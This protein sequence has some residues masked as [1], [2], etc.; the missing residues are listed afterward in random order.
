M[1]KNIFLSSLIS[2]LIAAGVGLTY[3]SF[4]ASIIVD[5]S[6]AVSSV[7][8]LANYTLISML[9][10]LLYF[11]LLKLFPSKWADFI[12]SLLLSFFSVGLVFYVMKMDDPVFKNEDAEL[13]KDF[14]KGFL[15]PLLFLPALCWLTMKPLFVK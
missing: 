12:I 10:G 6:E 11:G 4:Y 13:M 14:F 7:K 8:I 5:F 3:T 15:M 1:Y 2:A 9:A